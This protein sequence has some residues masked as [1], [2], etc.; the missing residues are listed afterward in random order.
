MKILLIQSLAPKYDLEFYERI[1][2]LHGTLELVVCADLRTRHALNQIDSSRA[3]PFTLVDLPNVER[4]GM[5]FRP[6]LLRLIRQQRPDVVIFSGTPR[7]VSQAFGLLWCRI[8]GVPAAAWGMFHRI[9]GPRLISNLYF[10][11]AGRT[12]VKCMTYSRVGASNLVGLGV[13]KAKIGIVGTAIDE[14]VP[15]RER[16]ARSVEELAVFKASQGLAGK[17]IVLQVVRL[18][19]IKK[20]DILVHAAEIL[21]EKRQDVVFV[22]IGDGDLRPKIEALLQQRG[23]AEHFRLVGS[24]Y[25]EALLS[26]WFLNAEAFVVPTCIGLSAHHAMSYGLPVI[27]DDSL[28]GQ[29]SEFAIVAD[30][31]NALLYRE[32]DHASLAKCIDR[33][34]SDTDYRNLLSAGATATVRNIHTLDRKCRAFVSLAI[35]A[36]RLT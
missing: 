16:E 20:P 11:H 10:R 28:D 33:I 30:G 12:A 14:R 27:T 23:L 5:A 8:V 19:A 7:D 22:L 3:Y 4:L 35:A 18:S 6:G 31:L 32:G 29:A 9:G 15:L 13:P 34:I 36:A 24:I 21:L 17:K 2:Q 25:D 26:R 1:C